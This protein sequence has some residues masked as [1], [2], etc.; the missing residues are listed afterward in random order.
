MLKLKIPIF[1]ILII[2][3]RKHHKGILVEVNNI[4]LQQKLRKLQHLQ[5]L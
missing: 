3:M 1:L 4:M 2:K 5:L